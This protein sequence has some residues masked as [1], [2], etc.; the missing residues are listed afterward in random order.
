MDHREY[1]SKIMRVLKVLVVLCCVVVFDG[2]ARQAP[3]SLE[4]LKPKDK[5]K[6]EV[7]EIRMLLSRY[8]Y[9]KAPLNDSLSNVIFDNYFESLDQNKSYFYQSDVN[10]FEKYRN[11]LDDDLITGNLDVPFQIFRIYRDRANTRLNHVLSILE[12]D[13]FDFSRDETFTFSKDKNTWAKNEKELDD[14]WRKIVKNQAL[15]L[16]LAG[17]S[18]SAVNK[19]LIQRYKRYRK[20]INQY[21]SDDVFQMFMN[22]YTETLDPHTNYFSPV[23]SDNFNINMSLSLEGIGAR[24]TQD[25]DYTIIDEKIPG[26]PA[27]KSK[28]LFKEDKIIG[29]AQG[30]DGEFVDVIGWRLSDVV[31]LIRGPKG[32]IVRLQVIRGKMTVASPVVVRLERDKI[33]LEDQAAK[34]EIIP[35]TEGQHTYKLGVITIPSFYLDFDAVRKGLDDYKSTTRDVSNLINE[36]KDQDV[37]G[38]LIDLRYNGGGSLEEAIKLT[39]IFIEQ[40][41]VVQVKNFDGKVNIHQDTDPKVLYDGP[42]AVLTNRFS[43]SAS[44]IFSGAIQD[45]KRGIVLGET[46]FG[47]GTVQRMVGLDHRLQNYPEK[48]GNLK[49]TLQMFYRV[50]GSSTQN[51][52]VVPD[53]HFPA[54]FS[55]EDFGESAKPSALPWEKIAS[56][57]YQPVN[58]ISDDMKKR[59]NQLYQHHLQTDEDLKKLAKEL[60]QARED[61]NKET[62]SLNYDLRKQEKDEQKEDSNSGIEKSAS[63]STSEI[64]A[65]EKENKKL[66]EDAYLKESLRLLAELVRNQ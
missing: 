24:L 28:D 18:D 20:N 44:E 41:P 39:G 26:G 1:K 50:T 11:R 59:L 53:V 25:L 8:S 61:R 15:N 7:R 16:K 21:N 33:K 52:G 47:K 40:G 60:E 56:S 12:K 54:A 32:S 5:H 62:V 4:V 57:D 3:D 42:L 36:L 51:I 46:T 38:V 22:A 49:L 65:T 29:V 43:A 48:L 10:Y 66:K 13:G 6:L 31:Q 63:V 9:R 37:D 45:Y 27:Y 14:R 2:L 64:A 23:S 35:I 34:S 17:K 58:T 30:D 19:L 55:A